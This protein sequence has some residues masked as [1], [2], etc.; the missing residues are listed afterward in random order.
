MDA[1]DDVSTELAV[2]KPSGELA[3]V[4]LLGAELAICKPLL[5]EIGLD[6]PSSF[7]L[8][9]EWKFSQANFEGDDSDSASSMALGESQGGRSDECLRLRR[10]ARTRVGSAAAHTSGTPFRPE[11]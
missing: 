2:A 11:H 9:F 5:A 10:L 1:W 8:D 4:K 7:E 6:K 3:M